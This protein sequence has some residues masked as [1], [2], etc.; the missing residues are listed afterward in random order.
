[1]DIETQELIHK[2]KHPH[3]FKRPNLA[4]P[5]FTFT[6]PAIASK[7]FMWQLIYTLLPFPNFHS[8]VF[9]ILKKV[10]KNFVKNC[11]KNE[12]EIIRVIE[13]IHSSLNK[14]EQLAI[15]KLLDDF[16]DKNKLDKERK[17]MI[18]LCKLKFHYLPKLNHPTD[19]S[20]IAYLQ[21]LIY[22]RNFINHAKFHFL[23]IRFQ[24]SI[25]K[26]FVGKD[27]E[28]APM[29]L[30]EYISQGIDVRFLR[31]YLKVLDRSQR[32]YDALF[33][34]QTLLLDFEGTDECFYYSKQCLKICKLSS[35][36]IPSVFWRN[37]ALYYLKS[38]TL[39]EALIDLYKVNKN[40][41]ESNENLFKDN[42]VQVLSSMSGTRK[43]WLFFEVWL[44]EKKDEVLTRINPKAF[45]MNHINFILESL[46]SEKAELNAVFVLKRLYKMTI[47]FELKKEEQFI[48]KLSEHLKKKM[49]E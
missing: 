41:F 36:E 8:L 13:Q 12:L 14:Q 11:D 44:N 18:S 49:E 2:R 23:T 30:Q 38:K 32:Y 26:Y 19:D 29:S 22:K 37:F 6:N 45:V 15:N 28:N 17:L 33:T 20:D 39:C 10:L 9:R 31:V 5:N 21:A 34:I 35:A 1:M 4:F 27:F 3:P 25:Q 16:Y 43:I 40:A 7:R 42:V 46:G 48:Q 47:V 24:G